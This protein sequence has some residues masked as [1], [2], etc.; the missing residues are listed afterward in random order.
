MP[1]TRLNLNTLE[2]KHFNASIKR[3]RMSEMNVL[4]DN[5][6][7][8][9][10]VTIFTLKTCGTSTKTR[11]YTMAKFPTSRLTYCWKH[12]YDN[13]YDSAQFVA[14]NS[15]VFINLFIFLFIYYFFLYFI[16]ISFLR[17]VYFSCPISEAT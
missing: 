6:L 9:T 7:I 3:G 8:L 15:V 12:N 5:I 2:L 16:Y 4:F 17:L 14:K 1:V 13:F 11:L 10:C